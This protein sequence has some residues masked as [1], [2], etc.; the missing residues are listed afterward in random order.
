MGSR[1]ATYVPFFGIWGLGGKCG[2]F[3]DLSFMFFKS[4]LK[5]KVNFSTFHHISC[6]GTGLQVDSD[7]GEGC[8]GFSEMV[9]D[10]CKTYVDVIFTI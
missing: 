6:F 2:L 10:L 1:N 4:C 5:S 9:F 8:A 3:R 7:S